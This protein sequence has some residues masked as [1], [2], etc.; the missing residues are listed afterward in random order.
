LKTRLRGTEAG[1]EWLVAGGLLRRIGE[2]G[3]P[4]NPASR[5]V[6]LRGGS[7]LAP[8]KVKRIQRVAQR[9]CTNPGLEM[10]AV[11]PRPHPCGR[12][13]YSRLDGSGCVTGNP[14]KTLLSAY[15]ESP[16][17]KEECSVRIDDDTLRKKRAVIASR[18]MDVRPTDERQETQPTG[19]SAL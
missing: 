14:D 4:C 9:F 6:A 17:G 16:A 12:A 1:K 2:L 18:W 3:R 8:M 13:V 15:R 19:D 7:P 5:V 10:S 11:N